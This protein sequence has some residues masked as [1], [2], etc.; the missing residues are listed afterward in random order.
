VREQVPGARIVI[1]EKSSGTANAVHTAVNE[2]MKSE[3]DQFCFVPADH[4][5]ENVDRFNL[6]TQKALEC[7]NSIT[8]LSVKPENFDPSYGYILPTQKGVKFVE[9]PAS[10]F[11]GSGGFWNTGIFVFTAGFFLSE[12]EKYAQF[13]LVGSL[14]KVLIEKTKKLRVVELETGWSDLGTWE[15]LIAYFEKSWLDKIKK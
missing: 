7:R 4:M 14:D 9:K 8:L 10:P 12:M 1:E 5:V 11:W 3:S 2:L 15:R 6:A 13:P